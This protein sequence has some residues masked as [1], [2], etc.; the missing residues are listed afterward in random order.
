[1]GGWGAPRQCGPRGHCGFHPP[2]ALREAPCLW[3]MLISTF[4]GYSRSYFPS[5]LREKETKIATYICTSQPPSPKTRS[6][7]PVTFT[8][9]Q[10]QF[11]PDGT[12]FPPERGGG[13]FPGKASG[14]TPEAGGMHSGQHAPGVLAGR[15]AGMRG[16]GRRREP[17]SRLRAGG[18][19]FG[20]TT[21]GGSPP[22]RPPGCT[23][24]SPPL[25]SEA[26]APGQSGS[27][28]RGPRRRPP[29]LGRGLTTGHAAPASAR[30]P[31]Y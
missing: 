13:S 22:A 23:V 7:L 15:S 3:A 14:S 31:Q 4:G 11:R 18:S 9:Y 2:S 6:R 26:P 24:L 30:G 28:G 16:A 5:S 12:S 29:A 20:R 19:T 25:C 21:R 8:E 1:M 10:A 17:E 27:S